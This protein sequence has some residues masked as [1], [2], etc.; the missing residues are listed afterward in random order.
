M[1]LLTMKRC[2]VHANPTYYFY[3]TINE[4]F[5]YIVETLVY[6]LPPSK[7][8]PNWTFSRTKARIFK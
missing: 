4:D 1:S 2:K 6:T 5:T 8:Y 3:Y 7:W